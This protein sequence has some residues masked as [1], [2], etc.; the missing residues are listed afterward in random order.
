VL[1]FVVFGGLLGSFLFLGL[2][3]IDR[4]ATDKI[5]QK[6]RQETKIITN[7]FKLESLIKFIVDIS[8]PLSN[9]PAMSNSSGFS[10]RQNTPFKPNEAIS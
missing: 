9:K 4:A 7:I 1:I 10:C 3:I 2:M 8:E 6:Q 5:Y